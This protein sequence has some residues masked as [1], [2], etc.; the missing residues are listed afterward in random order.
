MSSRT[1]SISEREDKRKMPTKAR[2]R[3]K[4]R[5]RS[6]SRVPTAAVR[7]CRRRNTARTVPTGTKENK[8]NFY[9]FRTV[10]L[11]REGQEEEYSL[12]NK[13][14]LLMNGE[15][16]WLYDGGTILNYIDKKCVLGLWECHL[17]EI[18]VRRTRT[19][20][21]RESRKRLE[22]KHLYFLDIFL[23]SRTAH[24]ALQNGPF[25][26]PIRLI[27]LFKTACFGE[28]NGPF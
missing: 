1:E 24:S 15:Q 20:D 4:R 6:I 5:R 14:E 19:S 16:L 25:C 3:R 13:S 23:A 7:P 11:P 2:W 12:E 27:L 18:K 10:L 8:N 9:R 28:Q 26:T 21:S 17:S 22:A